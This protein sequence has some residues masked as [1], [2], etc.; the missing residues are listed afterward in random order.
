MQSFPVRR[1]PRWIR[2]KPFVSVSELLNFNWMR[3][4]SLDF[5]SL[6]GLRGVVA[7][8]GEQAFNRAFRSISATG[9]TSPMEFE[10]QGD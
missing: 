4:P 10:M 6:D 7:V 8:A 2:L 5:V 9:Y 3:T 1:F